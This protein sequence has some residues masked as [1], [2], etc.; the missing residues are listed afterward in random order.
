[1]KATS[2]L[3]KT[4]T[5]GQSAMNKAKVAYQAMNVKDR[6]VL[7]GMLGVDAHGNVKVMTESFALDLV[8]NLLQFR[9]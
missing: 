2:L 5:I 1:M 7:R 4:D 8:K 6:A 3:D 9:Q